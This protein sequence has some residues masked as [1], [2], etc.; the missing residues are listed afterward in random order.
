MKDIEKLFNENKEAFDAFEPED[1]HFER[2][3]AK[4]KKRDRKLKNLSFNLMYKVIS[5]AA[6]LILF[7]LVSV[8]YYNENNQKPEQKYENL[9][10]SDISEEYKE[11]ETYLKSNVDDKLQEFQS[12]SCTNQDVSIEMVLD[13]LKELDETYKELQE[14]LKHNANDQ[15]IIDAMIDCYQNKIELLNQIISQVSKNC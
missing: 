9:T 2:F 15:R 4:I 6:V 3:R 10:L 7:A 1:G 13:E 11:V 8:K 12:L 5:I 14:E